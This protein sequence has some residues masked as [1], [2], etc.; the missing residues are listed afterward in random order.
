MSDLVMWR[1]KEGD[2]QE[3]VK[4]PATRV[5]HD[6]RAQKRDTTHAGLRWHVYCTVCARYRA[7]YHRQARASIPGT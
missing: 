4:S 2:A 6:I 1:G 7:R 3:N 5:P